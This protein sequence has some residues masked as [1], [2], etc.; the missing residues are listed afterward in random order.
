MRKTQIASFILLLVLLACKPSTENAHNFNTKLVGVNNSLQSNL[1]S[2]SGLVTSVLKSHDFSNLTFKV[3][4]SKNDLDR[5]EA[6][7][8]KYP[9]P[10]GGE[11]FK[12]AVLD[13]IKAVKEITDTYA[14]LS[15]LPKTATEKEVSTIMGKI[16][17]LYETEEAKMKAAQIAQE[18]FAKANR[19]QLK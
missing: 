18:E 3:N 2:L 9:A 11:K 12:T 4:N 14:L 6:E 1:T 5:C 13:Y 16:N 17:K 7:V 15:K 19:L 10:E 8:K